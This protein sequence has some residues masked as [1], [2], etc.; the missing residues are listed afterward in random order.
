MKQIHPEMLKAI[1]SYYP[2]GTRMALVRMD[3]P[4]TRLKPG[5][6][7][8]VSFVDDTGTVFVDWDSGSHLGVVFGED[9]IIKIDE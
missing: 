9:G 8:G 4:Y 1:R 5:D 3:D 7:G 6:Q 2:P